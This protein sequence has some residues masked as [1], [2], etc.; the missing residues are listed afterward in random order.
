LAAKK[1]IDDWSRDSQRSGRD[2]QLPGEVV[3]QKTL[4]QR[5]SKNYVAVVVLLASFSILGVL[6][7]HLLGYDL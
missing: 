2:W 7:L 3:H 4:Q 6:T 1:Q 5:G